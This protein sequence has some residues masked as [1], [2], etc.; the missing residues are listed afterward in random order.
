MRVLVTGGSG[1]VGSHV[2]RA[3]LERGHHVVVIDDLSTGDRRLV[4]RS[5][6]EF[7]EGDAGDSTLLDGI[8]RA[9]TIDAVVHI[10]G[11]SIVPESVVN[12]APYWRVN[13]EV[14]LN[15]LEAMRRHGVNRVVFSSTG[16]VYGI[17]KTIPINESSPKVPTSPYGAS[18]RSFEHLLGSYVS[19]YGFNALALRY[20]NVVGASSK[21]DLGEI[22][23]P[24]THVVPNLIEHAVKGSEF[25]LFGTNHPTRDGTAERDYVHVEDL[26]DAH[27]TAVEALGTPALKGV[28]AMNLGTGK[29]TT[30]R[31]LI[32]AVEKVLQ[33]RLNVV[34]KP[35]RAGDP[36]ALVAN[37][38]LAARTLGIRCERTIESAIES[39]FK[40][41][42]GLS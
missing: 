40:F 39:A 10:A 31:E 12:P 13:L 27:V 25:T 11:R 9:E 20:F 7:I 1:Y 6:A 14:G 24:E 34:E 3:F 28:F 8:F 23:E 19:A 41:W 18:K 17:P 29:G 32:T 15:L 37:P 33:T 22:H 16:S 42:S 5:G 2:T 36:P 38:E 21:G 4:E 35:S 26:A 30:V